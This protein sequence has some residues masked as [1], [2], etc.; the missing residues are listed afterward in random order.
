M[1]RI[2]GVGGVFFKSKG[3][4]AAL[5]AWYRKHRACRWKKVPECRPDH[6]VDIRRG[7]I[8]TASGGADR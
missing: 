7:A 3:D 6:R 2:T 8:N 4:S 5:A 1:A